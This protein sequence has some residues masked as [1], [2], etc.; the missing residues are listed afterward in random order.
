[1]YK[2]I[3]ATLIAVGVVSTAVVTA[4]P[5]AAFKIVPAE[6]SIPLKGPNATIGE[7]WKYSEEEK[8]I[9]GF[10][11]HNAIDF[12]APRNTP[13]YAAAD[14]YAISSFHSAPLVRIHQWKG[15]LGFGLGNFVQ[16]WH[17]ELGVYTSYSHLER[18]NTKVVPYIEPKCGETSCDPQVVYQSPDDIVK[19]AK[20]V[21]RG[22]LIGWVGDTGLGWGYVDK[23]GVRPDPKQFPSWDH[24][25]LHFEVYDRDPVRFLKQNRYDPYGWY[26]EL[27]QYQTGKMSPNALWKVDTKGRPVFAH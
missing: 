3:I 19:V 14:G 10:A 1:M 13:V 12:E 27:A 23:P 9:H 25:H 2:N 11:N 16:M 5:A 20:F 6:L 17:P 8:S 22:E 4:Q 21:K 7:G 18:V 26:G 15:P 24:T